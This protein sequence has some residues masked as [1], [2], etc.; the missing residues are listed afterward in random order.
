[1][2]KKDYK[3]F[4]GVNIKGI[5][6]LHGD[7]KDGNPAQEKLRDYL[8]GCN[9]ETLKRH[10]EECL[11]EKF[12]GCGFV[13]Q[14]IVNTLAKRLDLEVVH[15]R[16]N[17]A[18]KKENNGFDGMWKTHDHDFVVE[19]KKVDDFSMNLENFVKYRDQLLQEGRIDSKNHS[20]L[21][22]VG[23]M[24]KGAFVAQVKGD[25]KRAGDTRIITVESLIQ[26]V[27]LKMKELPGLNPDYFCEILK[28]IDYTRVDGLVTLLDNIVSDTAEAEEDNIQE[29]EQNKQKTKSHRQTNDDHHNKIFTTIET[30]TGGNLEKKGR[31]RF[32]NSK[33]GELFFILFSREYE[34]KKNARYWYAYDPSQEGNF[35][36]LCTK[37]PRDWFYLIPTETIKGLINEGKLSLTDKKKLCNIHIEI[38]NGQSKM[39]LKKGHG[40]EDIE[41]YKVSLVS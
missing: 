22:V 32:E 9:I 14:D 29:M 38:S 36:A 16:Y 10:A 25:L 20:F 37:E 11:E 8:A 17:R 3:I 41:Q 27:E 15:G 26:L 6:G 13:L 1:M 23:D 35:L 7:L 30:K 28:P 18:S 21:L 19:V 12:D 39:R 40:E 33:T 34:H 5:A 31:A 2:N 24:K 4:E